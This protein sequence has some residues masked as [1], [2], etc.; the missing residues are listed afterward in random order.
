MFMHSQVVLNYSNVHVQPNNS[1][2]ARRVLLKSGCYDVIC[3]RWK[4]FED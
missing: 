1:S 3:D 4:W 2:K